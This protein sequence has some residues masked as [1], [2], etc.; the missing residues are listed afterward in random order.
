MKLYKDDLN[1]AK[2]FIQMLEQDM[3]NVDNLKARITDFMNVIGIGN[4]LSG[5]G[6]ESIK[7]K[8]SEYNSILD[9]RK[10][11]AIILKTVINSSLSTMNSYMG[12]YVYLST[13]MID[14]AK[15]EIAS[16]KAKLWEYDYFVNSAGKTVT[17]KVKNLNIEAEINRLYEFIEYLER[18]IPTDNAAWSTVSSGANSIK[19]LSSM[20]SSMQ[21][22]DVSNLQAFDNQPVIPPTAQVAETD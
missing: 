13:D 16:L 22:I 11:V 15:A 3:N 10:S 18:M 19:S 5:P 6:Y 2:G 17:K 7:N 20:V 4:K 1:N 21:S 8:L 12:G 14:L 9:K